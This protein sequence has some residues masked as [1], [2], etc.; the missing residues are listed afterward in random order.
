VVDNLLSVLNTVEK[1]NAGLNETIVQLQRLVT[2][3][4]G[5]RDTIAASLTHIDDLATNSTQLIS[6]I[7]PYLPSDLKSLAALAHNLNTTKDADGQNTLAG[8][9]K[10]EPAKLNRITRTATYGGYFNFWLCELNVAGLPFNLGPPASESP[11]CP[12]AS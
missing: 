6:G 5:D 9:L 8:I 11:S 4:A 2:G 12:A 7:R 1:R 10:R 3:L